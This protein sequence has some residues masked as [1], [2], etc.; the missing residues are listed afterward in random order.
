MSPDPRG[1][2]VDPIWK[3]GLIGKDGHAYPRLHRY[4]RICTNKLAEAESDY[5]NP[6]KPREGWEDPVMG[7][8]MWSWDYENGRWVELKRREPKHGEFVNA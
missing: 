1:S 6:W 8:G 7:V 4:D 2:C 5:D 3:V